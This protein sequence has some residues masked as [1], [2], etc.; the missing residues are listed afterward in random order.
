[1]P[2]NIA[3]TKESINQASIIFTRKGDSIMFRGIVPLKI[4]MFTTNCLTSNQN[5]VLPLQIKFKTLIL[6]YFMKTFMFIF[7]L[8]A[9]RSSFHL[10]IDV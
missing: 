3:N 10:Y 9:F 8:Y 5:K 4:N 2:E 6:C 7:L 1:M